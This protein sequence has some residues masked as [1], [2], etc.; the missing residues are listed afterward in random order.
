MRYKKHNS[1][2]TQPEEVSR[3]D[4]SWFTGMYGKTWGK[5]R[6][7]RVSDICMIGNF[8]IRN[9]FFKLSN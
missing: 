6:I 8:L 3:S 1:C 2:T 7:T 5:K 4:G 9:A